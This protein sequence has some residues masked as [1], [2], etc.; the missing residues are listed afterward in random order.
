MYVRDKKLMTQSSE[1]WFH[2]KG[3]SAIDAKKRQALVVRLVVLKRGGRK[4]LCVLRTK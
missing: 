2:M 1:F 3:K 4:V